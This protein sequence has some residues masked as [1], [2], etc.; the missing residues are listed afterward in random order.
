MKADQTAGIVS[1]NK[2]IERSKTQTAKVA[3]ISEE[4]VIHLFIVQKAISDLADKWIINSEVILSITF[5]KE[6]F[7]NYLLFRTSIPI[8]LGDNSIIKAV[9]L[10][11]VRISIIVNRISK[12]F[13][14]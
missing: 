10:E 6:W 2:K 9:K 11:L 12:L 1:K 7:V 14:L 8:G 3:A 13:E 4:S 5:R